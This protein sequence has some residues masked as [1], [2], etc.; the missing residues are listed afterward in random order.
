MQLLQKVKGSEFPF[1]LVSSFKTSN[2]VF[3]SLYFRSFFWQERNIS[4][5][6]FVLK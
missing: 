1:F 4:I 2:I 3:F 6:L 5:A